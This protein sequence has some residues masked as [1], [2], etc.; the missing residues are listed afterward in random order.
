MPR[1]FTSWAA[2]FF[3]FSSSVFGIKEVCN[4]KSCASAFVSDS[5]WIAF[6]LKSGSIQIN[7]T[8]AVCLNRCGEFISCDRFIQT[9]RVCHFSFSIDGNRAGHVFS[10]G[11]FSTKLLSWRFVPDNTP[12]LLNIFAKGFI[13]Y[14]LIILAPKGCLSMTQDCPHVTHA[15][16]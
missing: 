15:R 6:T 14:T 10:I 2:L 1:S 12:L 16:S 9:L 7:F 8:C 3:I 13:S 5:N 4:I 11:S